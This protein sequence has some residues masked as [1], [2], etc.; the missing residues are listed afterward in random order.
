MVISVY[1]PQTPSTHT[2]S[3]GFPAGAN[4]S[5]VPGPSENLAA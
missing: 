5:V 4:V 1:A 2:H 3:I